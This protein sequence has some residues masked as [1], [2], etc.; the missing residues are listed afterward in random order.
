MSPIPQIAQL[1]ILFHTFL[2][3][4]M[5]EIFWLK[6]F[7]FCLVFHWMLP[8]CKVLTT[9]STSALRQVLPYTAQQ[10]NAWSPEAWSKTR[11]SMGK[12]CRHTMAQI[13]NSRKP[14]P[15]QKGESSFSSPTQKRKKINQQVR[16]RRIS[17]KTDSPDEDVDQGKQHSPTKAKSKKRK[18]LPDWSSDEQS[19][20]D[21]FTDQAQSQAP[22]EPNGGSNREEQG[23]DQKKARST[24][25]R[26]QAVDKPL[27]GSDS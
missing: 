10:Y 21:N 14:R 18:H 6:L 7:K 9:P 26:H 11:K 23:Q 17:S 8:N 24:P 19:C 3:M 5:E 20:H 27:K 15:W 16:Q 22:K 13:Q 1:S 12:R 2:L 4:K 25:L